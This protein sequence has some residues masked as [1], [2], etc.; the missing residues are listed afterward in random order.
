MGR[1]V[2]AAPLAR[3]LAGR[4]VLVTRERRQAHGLAAALGELGAEVLEVPL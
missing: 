2:S 1:Q 4:R 3:P